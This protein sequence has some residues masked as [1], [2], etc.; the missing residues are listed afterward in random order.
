MKCTRRSTEMIACTFV[1]LLAAGCATPA[2]TATPTP[3]P[4]PPTATLLPPASPTPIPP[5]PTDTVPPTAE[6]TSV[7]PLPTET[8]P[9]IATRTPL[10]PPISPEF[11]AGTFFH[12][13]SG[14]Y[15]CVWQFNEDGTYSYYWLIPSTDVSGRTPYFTGTYRIGDNL[16]TETSEASTSFAACESPATYAWT[17]DG[18]TLIFQV[19][20]ED[21]C[22]DRQRTYE[23]P[24]QWTKLE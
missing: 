8:S 7:A 19:V 4:R 21:P 14:G 6:P 5:L 12:K 15:F 1:L 22:P 23:A 18:K 17:F 2:P 20:G 13:H 16:Y 10:P 11:P 9:P 24:L 3:V